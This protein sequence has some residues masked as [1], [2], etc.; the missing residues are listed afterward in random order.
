VIF[1]YHRL[2]RSLPQAVIDSLAERLATGFRVKTLPAE[3]GAGQL[4]SWL[5]QEPSD[6]AAFG[7]VTAATALIVTLKPESVAPANPREGLDVAILERRIFAELLGLGYGS[8]DDES[9]V[10]YTHDAPGAVE[11]VRAGH[12]QAAILLRAARTEHLIAVA[13][14]GQK[15]PR[16]STYFYPKPWSGLVIY[17]FRHP[18]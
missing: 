12:S 10:S 17:H 5:A 2:V 11:S 16:K 18:P 1:P 13:D 6:A 3:I 14:A 7:I 15:M 8:L 4:L 9:R